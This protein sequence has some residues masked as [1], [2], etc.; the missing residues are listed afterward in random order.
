MSVLS[1]PV[2]QIGAKACELL[3]DRVAGADRR[4]SQHRLKGHLIER[5]SVAAPRTAG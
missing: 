5:K 3:L 2:Y 1:Q 4:P